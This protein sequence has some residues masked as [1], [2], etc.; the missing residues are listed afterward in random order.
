MSSPSINGGS[1]FG[2][3]AINKYQKYVSSGLA[4]DRDYH[5]K[6]N[7]SCSHYGQDAIREY[8]LA[9]GSVMAFMRMM[10]CHKSAE[11]GYDPVIPKKDRD[12]PQEFEPVHKR[13]KYKTAEE[14]FSY[15]TAKSVHSHEGHEAH[16]AHEGH[17]VSETSSH[18][19]PKGI[20]GYVGHALKSCVKATTTLAG[21]IAG[22]AVFTA[23]GAPLGIYLGHKAG[24]DKIDDVNAAIAKKYS[25]ESVY[26]F[27]KIE[28][29]L[30]KPSYKVHQFVETVTGSHTAAR[31]AGTALGGPLGL[32]MGVIRGAKSGFKTGA[33]YGRLFGKSLT[34]ARHNGSKKH[35]HTSDVKMSELSPFF[36]NKPDFKVG[37]TRIT[38]IMKDDV[39][40]AYKAFIDSAKE[41][42]DVNI[43]SF[44]SNIMKDLI[45]KKAREGV[46]VR[47][48]TNLGGKLPSQ[49][50]EN[51]IIL[52]ELEQDGVEVRLY[53]QIKAFNQF[54]HSKM[55]IVDGKAASVGTRNW[56]TSFGNDDDFD[57][58]FYMTGDTVNDAQSVFEKDWE[59]S[60]G[61]PMDVENAGQNPDARVL[62]NEPLKS[63]ITKEL[64]SNIENAKESIDMSLYWLTDKTTLESLVEA[65]NR[66]VNVRVLMSNSPHNEYAHNF[67]KKNGIDS[68]V[69]TPPKT[70]KMRSHFHQKMSIFDDETIIMGSCDITPQ[71]LYLN[72]EV[73]VAVKS[74]ELSAYMK[75]EYKKDWK[76]QSSRIAHFEH[77]KE[78]K[79]IKKKSLKDKMLDVS[80]RVPASMQKAGT[81][82]A[83]LASL[84]KRKLAFK[85]EN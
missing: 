9:E 53:P 68:Q 51:K 30:A 18:D 20:K 75:G 77:R 46:K 23:V 66:G 4:E 10:R 43:F 16:E 15:P 35:A 33:Q 80:Q 64:R 12:K 21:G 72:R 55:V 62:G 48:V 57:V 63:D 50:K 45:I 54:N 41:S 32:A 37:G 8:G 36:E 82:L 39:D 69:F 26:G 22:V 52:K 44:K 6:Y 76:N 81:L 5:C 56:G 71:G 34:R 47:V 28:N 65:K 42:I 38:P 27:G 61:K 83:S 3:W 13:Y 60:G 2:N 74:R 7:P 40:P 84:A 85:D 73:N 59:I 49:K 19:K 24:N 78:D 11:G 29:A 14:I 58:M 1:S 67:L 70:D 31:I 25:P 79:L 17:E